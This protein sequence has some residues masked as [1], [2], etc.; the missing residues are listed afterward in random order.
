MIHPNEE[1]LEVDLNV[2]WA[3][4]EERNKKKKHIS[5]DL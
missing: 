1:Q 5:A 4:Q 3:A 2:A